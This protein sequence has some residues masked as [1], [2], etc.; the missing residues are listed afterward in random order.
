MTRRR[1]RRARRW[2]NAA[3]RGLPGLKASEM[4]HW[5]DVNDYEPGRWRAVETGR[6]VTR[7]AFG[8][9][10]IEVDWYAGGDCLF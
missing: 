4:R 10:V 8:A 6:H 2:R 1:E 7:G 5:L 9:E 3:A